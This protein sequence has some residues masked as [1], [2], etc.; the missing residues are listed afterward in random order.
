MSLNGTAWAPI[1][2]SPVSEGTIEANGLCAAIAVLPSNPNVI[3]MGTAGGGIWRTE[4]GGVTWTPIFD[5]QLALGIGEPG[6]LT[7]DP[8]NPSVIYAG[9][10]ARNANVQQQAGL[11][12]STDGGSSWIQLGSGYPAGNT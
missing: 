9:T 11:F 6:A 3:Y 7:I 12:K 5:R 4:D 10:S 8:N 1:G 2:P